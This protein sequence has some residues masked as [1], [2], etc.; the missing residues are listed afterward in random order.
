MRLGN[1][2]LRADRPNL[3]RAALAILA[4][5]F[6]ANR[7]H[8][9]DKD[10]TAVMPTTAS[11]EDLTTRFRQEQALFR[12]LMPPDPDF[13]LAQPCG[14]LLF[15]WKAFPDA[16]NQGL[17]GELEKDYPLY[18]ILMAEDPTT[19]EIVFAN[20]DGKEIYAVKPEDA[21][22]PYWLL[23]SLYPDQTAAPYTQENLDRLLKSY[24][25]ARIQ[26]LFR[27]L[28]SD[29]A[30]KYLAAQAQASLAAAS[31]GGG[32]MMMG[33]SGP[34]VTNLVFGAIDRATNNILLTI[35]YPSDYTNRLDVF[36]TTNLVDFWWD[37]LVTTNINAATNWIE[38]LDTTASNTMIRFYAAGNA[39]LDS[40]SDGLT[41][42]AGQRSICTTR[43]PTR[44]ILM[45][46]A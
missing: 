32:M 33:Y 41:D 31:S 24:D 19:R 4:M 40:D 35:V 26:I 22:D 46:T 17:I 2:S 6:M 10:D 1:L 11:I 9:E 34:P 7:G 39:D 3:F 44:T 13:T 23:H 28:P 15:D 43:R 18:S 38:W 45:G 8:S 25:S 16:F 27:L 36:A 37:R 30:E 12:F 29:Y 14:L 5:F 42:A 21:Y 20:A